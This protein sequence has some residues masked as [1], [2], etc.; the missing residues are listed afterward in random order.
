MA[1]SLP[2]TPPLSLS[3]FEQNQAPDSLSRGACSVERRE[4]KQRRL[5]TSEYDS[6]EDE[7][8]PST[9]PVEP[10]SNEVHVQVVADDDLEDA[11]MHIDTAPDGCVSRLAPCIA[12]SSQSRS[13]GVGLSTPACEVPSLKGEP[14]SHGIAR[15]SKT[16]S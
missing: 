15:G 10:T 16:G 9:T 5:V 11:D 6:E 7:A 8:G 4:Q 13:S 2:E 3:I 1:V 14:R 12:H